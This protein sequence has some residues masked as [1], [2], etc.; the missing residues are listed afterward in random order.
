M[1]GDKNQLVFKTIVLKSTK[2]RI[3]KCMIN[4]QS[5]T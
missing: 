5:V 1:T 4:S 3:K 2:S